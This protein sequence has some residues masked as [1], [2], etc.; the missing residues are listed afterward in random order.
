MNGFAISRPFANAPVAERDETDEIDVPGPSRSSSWR[1]AFS[2]ARRPTLQIGEGREFA[3]FEHRV[4]DPARLSDMLRARAARFKT[5]DVGVDVLADRRR[6]VLGGPRFGGRE[7]ARP[8]SLGLPLQVGE[9]ALSSGLVAASG[10]EFD[11]VIV[12]VAVA[13]E[14]GARLDSNT[15]EPVLSRC[16]RRGPHPPFP[17][18]PASE[19]DPNTHSGL[20]SVGKSDFCCFR[21]LSDLG[22]GGQRSCHSFLE[23][24]A[25]DSHF[26]F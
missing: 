18:A 5:G 23:Y 2:H 21:P 16:H 8:H 20:G 25:H 24:A 19:P 7:Q 13:S 6:Q 22:P 11:D 14:I 26:R 12:A 1:L 4:D 15:V 3:P 9:D 17:V 10:R